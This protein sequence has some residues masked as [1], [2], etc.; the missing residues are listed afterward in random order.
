MTEPLENLIQFHSTIRDLRDPPPYRAAAAVPDWLKNMPPEVEI[1]GGKLNTAKVC[2]PFVDAMSSGYFIPLRATIRFSMRE[3]QALDYDHPDF[4]EHGKAVTYQPAPGYRGAPFERTLVVK[5]I[6]HWIIKTPPG[7]ST[8]ILPLLNQQTMPFQ[9]LSGV[10]DTDTY[11]RPIYLPALCLMAAGTQCVLERGAP[12]VQVIPFRREAWRSE[13]GPV[14]PAASEKAENRA[15][16][17]VHHYR[18][19]NRARKEFR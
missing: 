16:E 2:M 8:L 4:L 9:I 10:V 3:G 19:D 12:L 13:C 7:Y 15:R 18:D 5:F 6:N 1:P 17:N 11:Y 14:D